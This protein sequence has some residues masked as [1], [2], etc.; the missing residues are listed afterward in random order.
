MEA[1]LRSEHPPA[2][3]EGV[4]EGPPQTRFRRMATI[5]FYAAF[6]VLPLYFVPLP[7][8]LEAVRACVF[9][10]C[11]GG[12]PLISLAALCARDAAVRR[13]G[14]RTF[15]VIGINFVIFAAVGVYVFASLPSMD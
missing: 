6:P 12:S 11:F 4:D 14:A 1:A 8:V 7:G 3:A 2:D 10:V 5:A 15:A 13:I 9:L